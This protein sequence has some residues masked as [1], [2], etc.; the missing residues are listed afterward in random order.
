MKAIILLPL[1]VS[2]IFFSS[3]F[4][5][6]LVSFIHSYCYVLSFHLSFCITNDFFV[7]VSLS[8][9][10]LLTWY[11]ATIWFLNTIANLLSIWTV[12]LCRSHNGPAHQ[13]NL[14][15]HVIDVN[16]LILLLYV[17][18]SR[19]VEIR[20]VQIICNHPLILMML[21]FIAK[22]HTVSTCKRED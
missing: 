17:I 19:H 15:L 1:F 6:S 10:K 4:N 21:H 16:H 20:Y 18:T 7:V 13:H 8:N 3:Q 14:L 22:F 5:L 12:C 9:F 11:Q 2:F